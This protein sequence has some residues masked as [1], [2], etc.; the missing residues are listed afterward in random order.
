MRA[1]LALLVVLAACGDNIRP[2]SDAGVRPDGEVFMLC[3]NVFV[4]GTEAC[5]DGNTD[6]D[7]GCSPTCELECG[8]GAVTGA[9]LCDVGIDGGD[10]G[11]CPTPDTCVDND[12]CT[13]GVFS[14]AACES[15]CEFAETT[16]LID[17]DLCCPAGAD[18][19]TDT[20]CAAV[21]GNA[22]VESPEACD[23]G[24]TAGLAGAC[25]TACD[26]GED[27]TVDT[28]V[29]AGTCAAECS[30]TDIT[31]IGPV[32]GCCPAGATNGT[33]TDCPLDCGDGAVTG[34]ETCD[35]AIATGTGSCPT[36]CNDG[37]ACTTDNLVN[38]GTC[39]AACTTTPI[40]P[41]PTD[42]CCP[43]GSDLGDDPDCPA[44]CGD[45][46]ITAPETCD[47]DGTVGGDGCSATCR[48]EPIAFRFSDLDLKDPHVFDN[49]FGCIDVTNFDAFGIQ[50]VNPL[51]QDNIQADGDG[52]GDLDL[53]IANT[54]LPLVQ[55][56]GTM[57]ASDLVFPD[58]TAPLASTTCELAAGA[59]HIPATAT[60][61]G[62]T[63][64]CLAP[65]SMTT[66]GYTPAVVSPTAG[67]G[68]TCYVA[69]AGTVTFDL[70][71]IPI[72][73]TDAKIGGEWFGSPA[74]QVR[75][76]LISGFMSE[77]VAN[78]TI[79][80]EGTTGVAAIDGEPLSSLLRGGVNSCSRPSPMV[81]D[82][83]TIGGVVGWMFYLNFT[84][85]K[86]GYT[87]L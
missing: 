22:I 8:D 4:E 25:P 19:T 64:V 28:L 76:G 53:S 57:T 65:V 10:P 42:A 78:M 11:A 79:I 72:T 67:G 55:T 83:D 6:A 51:L 47:D 58:C 32:D 46:V 39:R 70:G 27:C 71:G 87:E 49:A 45:G 54:F 13:T 33:D 12:P 43:T 77:T 86:V 74:T 7:D 20:D 56:A 85:A 73:L 5:D 63:T 62:G 3:G 16:A 17:G 38:A 41:G 9:E 48:R 24:I 23:L 29:F 15:V 80:P 69:T 30:A 50:G 14:G 68:G 44:A 59:G 31:A 66:G 2:A 35:T 81:G 1:A 36:A 61:S 75:D 26:D 82:K 52:D 84:A 60:N 18:T 21:C 34:T 37:Q 40:G